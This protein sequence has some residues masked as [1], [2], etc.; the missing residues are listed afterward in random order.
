MLIDLFIGTRQDRLT[1]RFG[2]DYAET[3]SPA[4]RFESVQPDIALGAQLKLQLHLSSWRT[5]R[6]SLH[7]TAGRVHTGSD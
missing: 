6:R 5:P 3:F 2:L 1:Q 4:I 7:V